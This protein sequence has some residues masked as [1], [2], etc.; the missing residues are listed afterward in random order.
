MQYLLNVCD[1]QRQTMVVFTLREMDVKK[2]AIDVV[3]DVVA[4]DADALAND[5]IIP[6][7]QIDDLRTI[8]ATLFSSDAQGA[9]INDGASIRVNGKELD[10]DSNL[11]TTFMPSE[12]DGVK[13]WRS[14]LVVVGGSVQTDAPAAKSGGTTGDA[15]QETVHEFA[16]IM[17]LHQIASGYQIDVTKESAELGESV[18]EAE[19]N[20]W[21]EIDVQKVC[22]KLTEAGRLLYNGYVDEAQQLIQR[23]DIYGDVD[24]ASDG[25]IRFDTKLSQDLRVAIFDLE[26]VDPYRAR[27]LIGINDNEWNNFRDWEKLYKTQEFYETILKDVGY[28]PGAEDFDRNLLLRVIDRGKEQLRL[29]SRLR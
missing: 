17:F 27:Y 10:P 12:R 11:A 16:R 18:A 26:G 3:F 2:S 14:E 24:V 13:Y 20:G 7:G 23:Y 4:A 22:Y 28:A 6:Q 15:G 21:I 25:T 5:G 8:Q 29:D 9:F 19:K 1:E